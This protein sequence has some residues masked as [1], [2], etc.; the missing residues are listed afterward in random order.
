MSDTD[1][2]RGDAGGDIS[3][4]TFEK[5]REVFAEACELAPEDRRAFIESAC[6]KGTALASQVQELIEAHEEVESSG[7]PAEDA[8]GTSILRVSGGPEVPAQ[9]GPY[10]IQSVIGQGGMGVVYLARQSNPDREVALKI[11][12]RGMGSTGA[13]ARFQREIRVLGRLEHP[14]ITRIYEA[15]T[16]TTRDGP[17]AY[18]AMEFVRGSRLNDEA[19]RALDAR[20]RIELVARV[21]DAVQHAH[22][23]GVIH[24]DL[25][26][27]NILISESGDQSASRGGRDSG[28]TR[29]SGPQPKILDFGVARLLEPD[30]VHTAVTEAGLVIGTIG[31]M[32]P[33]QLAG[34]I[35]AVD[36]RSDIYSLGVILYELLTGRMPFDLRGKPIAEAARIVRDDEPA[37]IGAVPGLDRSLLADIQTIIRHATERDRDRRYATAAALSED[38]RRALRDEPILA[39]PPSA[40]YQLSKFARRNKGLVAGIGA[41][42]VALVAGVV[43]STALLVRAIEARKQAD[44]KERLATAVRGYMIDHLLLAAHPDRMGYEVKMLDVLTTAS[45]GLHERFAESPDVE[46]SIRADLGRVLNQIG[47]T[48]QSKTEYLAAIPLI[49]A[50][51]GQ[52]HLDTIMAINSLCTTL[53][54][55]A[56]NEE[57]LRWS[58]DSLERSR[59]SLGPEDVITLHAMVNVSGALMTLNR[60]EEAREVLNAGLAV[61]KQDPDRYAEPY[62]G[63]LNWLAACEDRSGNFNAALDIR[64]RL[65]DLIIA[66]QGED[67]RETIVLRANLAM[68]LVKAD[69]P[70][71]AAA[72]VAGLSQAMEVYY[73]PGHPLRAQALA[74]EGFVLGKA[75]RFPESETLL[76]RAYEMQVT[77]APEFD[78]ATEMRIHSLRG[79]YTLWP[80]HEKEFVHWGLHS[81]KGRMMLAHAHELSNLPGVI[82]TLI[83]QG[84]QAGVQLGRT[85]VLDLVWEARD[86]LAP[87]GHKRRAAFYGNYARA[88]VVEGHASRSAEAIALA[89]SSL[90]YAIEREVAEG[91][92]ADAR[93]MA[94]EGG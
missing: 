68:G 18:F 71:E 14:G 66:R 10:Q 76:L 81:V 70:Q 19:A 25:K 80:G 2:P 3:P 37:P 87:E 41:A 94:P 24:R 17:I 6:G 42:S 32:S 60:M 78:W 38:L 93:R 57:W 33:E 43:V 54:G 91:I 40:T 63:M 45:E 82:D 35:H 89:E 34:D 90:E 4:E 44:A 26:P 86:E 29:A 13:R 73:P 48:E 84:A 64:K 52:D 77:L 20:T 36:A 79:L 9:I 12:R 1:L 30:T 7:E 83:E 28:T 59:R 92:L 16:G 65:L 5:V 22:G 61:A 69:R 88:C 75:G 62:S 72:I 21:A 11:V 55:L 56:E 15:G 46:G 23:K 67:H 53:Q 49:E 31:Y 85:Q 39:R 8:L 51:R 50:S 58:R 27:A 74:T 47:K